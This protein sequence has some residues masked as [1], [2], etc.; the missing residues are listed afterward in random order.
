MTRTNPDSLPDRQFDAFSKHRSNG[1]EEFKFDGEL[2]YMRKDMS[3]A[4]GLRSYQ[5]IYITPKGDVNRWR[6]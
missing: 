6:K 5:Y 2:M 1:W 3:T 4:P